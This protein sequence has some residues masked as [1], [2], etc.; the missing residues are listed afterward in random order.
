MLADIC[1]ATELDVAAVEALHAANALPF[2][3]RTIN[4]FIPDIDSPFYGGIN[5]ALRI[6]DYLTASPRRGEPVRGLGHR[7]RTTSS[8]RRSRRR[9]RRSPMRRSASTTARP[10]PRLE[11]VPAADASIATLWVTAYAVAQ[12]AEHEAQ[13]LPGAGLRADVLPGEH[14]VRA[15]R[16]DLPARPVRP[17]QHRQPAP[18]LRRRLRA[19]RGCRSRPAIDPTVFHAK[20][21]KQRTAGRTGDRVR[22]RAAGPLAQL[23]GDGFAR[24]G[25]AEGAARRPGAH[26]HRRLVGEGCGGG[27]DASSSLGLLELP[28]HRRA[29]PQLRRRTGADRVRSTRRTCRSS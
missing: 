25:G 2:D 3:V 28:G 24:A 22:L 20:D 5:T 1:R 14:A 11:Q 18:D 13:V 10:A 15:H 21:R 9:S 16:G 29:V 8:G 26:R 17:V 12:G 23:L 19:A 4:W 6:A 7:A 27:R